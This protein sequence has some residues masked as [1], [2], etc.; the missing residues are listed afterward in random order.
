MREETSGFPWGGGRREN[1]RRLHGS[2]GFELDLEGGEDFCPVHTGSHV[3]MGFEGG[4]LK[5]GLER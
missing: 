4:G 5:G 3:C 2:S 1:Q